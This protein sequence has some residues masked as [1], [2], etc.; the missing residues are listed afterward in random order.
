M[1]RRWW[2]R[3]RRS[4]SGVAA[5][6]LGLIAPVLLALL[7]GILD[8]GMAYWEQMQVVNAADA[9]TQ[10]AMQNGYNATNISAT[11]Q[12]ATYLP[13]SSSDVQ[14][15]NVCGCPTSSGV[16]MYACTATCP[17]GSTPSQYYRVTTHI[18]YKTI[19][20]WPGLTYCSSGDSFCSSCSSNEIVL[21][22]QSVV[23]HN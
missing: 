1:T 19:F 15:V 20:T 22:S 17:D 16:A 10:W 5:I 2:S 12:N 4:T 13:L 8:F 6:E 3:L 9:G 23:A 21:T 18:C 14:A 11:A 7:L